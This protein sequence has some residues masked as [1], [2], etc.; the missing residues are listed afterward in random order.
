MNT[1]GKRTRCGEAERLCC[2]SCTADS[3][4]SFIARAGIAF[5]EC[6]KLLN[7]AYELSDADTFCAVVDFVRRPMTRALDFKRAAETTAFHVA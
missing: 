1:S 3:E 7:V 6:A 4:A 5:E 2:G